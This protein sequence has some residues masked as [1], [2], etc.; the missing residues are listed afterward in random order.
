MQINSNVVIIEALPGVGGD[1]SKLWAK[2]LLLSYIKFA[3]RKNFKYVYLDETIVKITGENAFPFFKNETGVHRVQRIPDTERK[4]R[5]HTSTCVIVVLPQILQ[6]DVRINQ[7]DLEWQF[8]RAGGHGGQNV[9]KVSTAV[10]L[11][12]KPTGVVVTASQERYQDANRKIA[13]DLLMGKLYQLEEEKKRGM[14][15]SYVQNIGTG[16]RADKIRTYNFP[17]NRLTDH[18]IGKSFHNL[19]DVISQGKWDKIFQ[20]NMV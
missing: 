2:E 17:Q 8:F 20:S 9:N 15:F 7:N 12:H 6:S 4:G 3:Q 13:L 11:T 19:D 14:M 16:E 5:I 1:E 18:R 10:R